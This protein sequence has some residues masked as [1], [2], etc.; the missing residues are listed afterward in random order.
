MDLYEILTYCFVEIISMVLYSLPSGPGPYISILLDVGDVYVTTCLTSHQL[1]VIGSIILPVYETVFDASSHLP[2]MYRIPVPM[3]SIHVDMN[4]FA[5]LS[6]PSI[7]IPS[8]GIPIILPL[9]F[10]IRYLPPMIISLVAVASDFVGSAPGVIQKV[11][12]AFHV[13]EPPASILCISPG[14]M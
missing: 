10:D 4:S 9:I 12:L 5:A 14:V 8:N 1:P 13:P 2:V 6:Y 3:L 7:A 11:T